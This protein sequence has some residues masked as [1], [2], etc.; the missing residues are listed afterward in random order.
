MAKTLISH[1]ILGPKTFFMGLTS[2]SSQTMF[3][4]IIYAISRKTNEPNLRKW[5]KKII[6]DLILACLAQIQVA[7]IYWLVL[8]L[9]VVRYYSK[10]SSYAISRKTN[11]P[12]LRKW[13]DLILDLILACLA[14]KKNLWVLPLLDVIH[15]CKQ[16]LHPIS[17]KT[18][19]LNLR[20]WQ[21]TQFQTQ[22]WSPQIFFCEFLP[23]LYVRNC[24]YQCM[25]LQGKIM[26]QT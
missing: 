23:L 9:L 8:P 20:K 24:C 4:A 7:K 19:E 11:E 21:K 12:N 22:F 15:C 14:K 16:S 18:N 1:P 2:T 25:Q 3:Q 17:R 13:Q 6:S 10:L 5:G 26:N